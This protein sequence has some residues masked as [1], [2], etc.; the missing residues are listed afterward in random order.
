L[1]WAQALL[2]REQL[3]LILAGWEKY[4]IANAICA[5]LHSNEQKILVNSA[6]ASKEQPLL[7]KSKNLLE[8]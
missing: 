4:M 1:L 6:T 7:N 5:S 8:K 2:S 3:L